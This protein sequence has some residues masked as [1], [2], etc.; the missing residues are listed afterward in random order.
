MH[1]K[2]TDTIII[3]H[4]DK[5]TGTLTLISI[6]RDL[7]HRGA[8]INSLYKN[9]GK[10]VFLHELSSILGLSLKKYIFIDM[11][12]FIDVI[13]ILGGIE[14]TLEQDLIDPTYK[15]Y[16]KGEWD[17]LYYKKG[18]YLLNGIEALR[19]ATARHFTPVFSRDERQQKILAAIMSKL[20]GIA[21]TDMKKLY[22]LVHLFL[23]YV[24]TNFSTL[25]LVDMYLRYG[26]L[27]LSEFNVLSTDN[28]LYETYSNLYFLSQEEQEREKDRDKGAWILLPK[29]NDWQTIRWYIMNIIQSSGGK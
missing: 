12:A 15:I 18:T 29:N 9:Y 16:E 20:K 6:P 22:D 5:D 27:K 25:E 24:E 7:Y 1:Q 28:V 23:T 4:I 19:V 2:N 17:T 8:K 14:V 13:N 10:D 26:H 11:Y 21:L 3:V